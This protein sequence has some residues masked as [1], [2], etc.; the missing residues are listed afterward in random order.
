MTTTIN[1]STTAGLVQTAD[2][3]GILALQTAGTTAI[4]IDAS[5][6]VNFAGTAQRITGD[7]SNATVA[8]RVMFQTSTVNG[9]SAISVIP[10]GTGT[11]GQIQGFSNSDPTNASRFNLAA[12]GGVDVRLDSTIAGTGTY[13]PMTFFT[14]GS[15][16]LRLSATTKAV[17]LAG[18]STSANGTGI[19]FPATQSASTDAN[20]LDDY[21]EGTWTVTVTPSTGSLTAYNQ[22]G[23]YTKVGR[24]VTL[25]FYFQI[26]TLGTA[27]GAATITGLPFS[28]ATSA[29][30]AGSASENAVSGI[31]GV[32]HSQS[33]TSLLVKTATGGTPF[34]ASAYW[35]CA[36]SY[37]S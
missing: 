1:A 16:S 8:S 5:Q 28:A 10:N 27:G 31:A 4:S 33:T 9:N 24:L 14:G 13:L 6:N 18:G 17:I 34:I 37:F 25:N 2:T 19:T 26:T 11:A 21:E 3:S 22:A 36:I 20:T 23:Q 15:E 35:M 32:V 7:F 30:S 29:I 12:I